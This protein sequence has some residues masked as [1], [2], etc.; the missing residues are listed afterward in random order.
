MKAIITAGGW[1]TRR[2]PIT[3]VIDKSMLPIGNRPIVDYVVDDCLKAGITEIIFVVSEGSTQV[4]DYYSRNKALEDYLKATGRGNELN[5]I[6]PPEG[7]T[8]HYLE[9]PNNSNK[10]GTAIPVAL[11]AQKYDFSDGAVVL[12]GDDFVYHQDDQNEVV[13]LIEEAAG[14]SSL[15]GVE[16]DIKLTHIY[17][18]HNVSKDGLL[19]SIVEKPKPG[20]APG[21]LINISKYFMCP[22]LLDYVI[23]YC[24]EDVDGEYVI[25]EPINR[26]C[27]DGGI[28]KVVKTSG[29]Y[30][31]GGTLDGWLEANRVVNH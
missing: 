30:L 11:A 2:L 27:N 31:D 5:Q 14:E 3:K 10:Y 12:M 16:V 20:T 21:N 1:G 19:Q 23:K 18:V 28:V 15:L 26:Y 8:F 24:G 29:R 4:Q 13:K 17:G 25:T 9:Q 22:K 6:L 7:A